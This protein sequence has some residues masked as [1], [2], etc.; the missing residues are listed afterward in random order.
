MPSGG[1]P[2]WVTRATLHSQQPSTTGPGFGSYAPSSADPEAP[3]REEC[4]NSSDLDGGSRCLAPTSHPSGG[5]HLHPALAALCLPLQPLPDTEQEAASSIP[6]PRCPHAGYHRHKLP[7]QPGGRTQPSPMGFPSK[8]TVSKGLGTQAGKMAPK[9]QA[10]PSEVGAPP[11]RESEAL[12]LFAG[13]CTKN[14]ALH[15]PTHTPRSN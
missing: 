3:Q 7:W 6:L 13:T 8:D 2:T 11:A 9:G 1:G 4:S 12:T 10:A 15:P 5:H 14:P